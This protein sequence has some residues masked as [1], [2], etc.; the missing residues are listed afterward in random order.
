MTILQALVLG[1]VQGVTEFLPVSSSGHLVL[2]PGLLGWDLQDVAFDAVIHLATLIA[3][4]AFFWKDI[5]SIFKKYRTIGWMILLATIPV[6]LVG[7]WLDQAQSLRT[8]PVVFCS[9]AF[10][11][12]VLII[13]DIY[14]EHA[15]RKL[16]ALS[17][18][19]WARVLIVG[20]AQAIAL[21]PGT[22]RSGITITAGLFSGMSRSLAT[23]MAFL[24]G[25]PAIAAAGLKK[26][27][28]VASGSVD[29]E[30]LPL[31]VGFIAALVSGYLVV[32]LLMRLIERVGY[33][34]FGVYRILVAVV[35]FL[36]WLQSLYP[37]V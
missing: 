17:E 9:L 21:I 16:E 3:I 33:K 37:P 27:F 23:R 1:L 24:V 19:R 26:S 15:K 2:F 14:S 7:M 20:I 5:I 22:S 30:I 32:M 6:G 13:A 34:W 31:A 29:L 10:W 12:I 35:L 11:G 8:L 25:I 28:D 36:I 18:I 4:V